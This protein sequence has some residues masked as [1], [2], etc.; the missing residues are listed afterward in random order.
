MERPLIP[1]I[2]VNEGFLLNLEVPTVKFHL[3]PH[4]LIPSSPFPTLTID[5]A[6]V[7]VILAPC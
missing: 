1:I 7:G 3:S 5:G 2:G 6:L 4:S